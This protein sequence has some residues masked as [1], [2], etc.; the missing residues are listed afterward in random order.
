[1][2]RQLSQIALVLSLTAFVAP[3]SH[4]SAFMCVG[5]ERCG[6]TRGHALP[7]HATTSTN[8]FT[9]LVVVVPMRSDGSQHGGI[10]GH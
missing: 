8:G 9:A 5:H 4:A 10:S 7:V 2:W 1:M 6:I 3:A